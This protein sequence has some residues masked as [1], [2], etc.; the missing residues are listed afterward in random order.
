MA[1]DFSCYHNTYMELL[2]R[3]RL[4]HTVPS[5]VA[6][7]GWFF[8]TVCCQ[9]RGSN[10][11]CLPLVAPFLLNEA[12]FYHHTARWHLHL[13][14]LMPDHLHAIAS[15]AA[16]EPMAKVVRDWKRLTARFAGVKWQRGFFDHRLRS[17]D[18]FEIKAR[19]VR[20]NPVRQ[21][22]VNNAETWPYFVDCG[23]LGPLRSTG[24]TCQPFIGTS[25][26]AA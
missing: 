23:V 17:K 19:Y 12:A 20:E 8:L 21:V 13:F 22:L 3:K 26:Q 7:G 10:Q 14:L 1:G 11:L 18:E 25:K 6:K 4:Y 2:L 15:F 5:F 16:D 9:Q 24:P